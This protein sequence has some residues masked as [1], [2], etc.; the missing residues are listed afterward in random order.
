MYIEIHLILKITYDYIFI[1]IH[2]CDNQLTLNY[3][4]Y[5]AL[6]QKYIK[7]T[8]KLKNSILPK[9]ASEALTVKSLDEV[10]SCLTL[11]CQE[12]DWKKEVDAVKDEASLTEF[13]QRYCFLSNFSLLKCITEKLGLKESKPKIDQ[14]AKERDAF[15]SEVFA[16]DFAAAAIEDHILIKEHHV[17]V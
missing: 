8:D 5:V 1:I 3:C 2:Y 16:K 7:M 14:L 10:K 13:L 4:F 17:E 12:A 15:Y 6:A 9:V 11:V